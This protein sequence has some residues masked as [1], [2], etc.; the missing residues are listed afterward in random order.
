LA[1]CT[2]CLL[3][4]PDLQTHILVSMTEEV[5]GKRDAG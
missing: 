4:A 5:K 3:P 1:S 2:F